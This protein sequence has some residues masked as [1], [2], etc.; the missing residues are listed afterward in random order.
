MARQKSAYLQK[1]ISKYETSCINRVK[2]GYEKNKNSC[3]IY[4]YVYIRIY[5]AV[6]FICEQLNISRNIKDT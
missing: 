3:I 6:Q 1:L 2:S 4:T 5:I